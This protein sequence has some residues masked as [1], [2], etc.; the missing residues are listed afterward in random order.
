MNYNQETLEQWAL[1][2]KQK[3]EDS[4]ALAKYMRADEDRIR[5]LNNQ[6]ESLSIEATNKKHNLEVEIT[7]T[8]AGQIELDRTAEEFRTLH[9]ERQSINLS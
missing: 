6:I 4:L 8:Q 5:S 7:E 3:D 2:A 9:L 1:A